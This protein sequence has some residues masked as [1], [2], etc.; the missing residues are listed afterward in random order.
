MHNLDLSISESDVE[1]GATRLLQYVRPE[2]NKA[3][4]AFKTFTDGI[5]NK[6]V[7]CYCESGP[8]DDLVLIRI[9]GKNTELLIDRRAE[10]ATMKRLALIGCAAPLYATFRNGICY[11]YVPGV[12]LDED[13]VRDETVRRLVAEMFVKFHRLQPDDGE[14]PQP[15][16]FPVLKQYHRLIPKSFADPERDRRL[17]CHIPPKAALGHELLVLEQHL[18]TLRSPVVFC[19]NDVL[20]KN[21]IY[22]GDCGR[23]TFIDYEY[24][25]FNYQAFDIG[26]HF[27]EFSGLVGTDFSR[28]PDRSFQLAWL[29]TYLEFWNQ[30]RSGAPREVSSC[31]VETLYVQVNKFALASHFMWG[32]WGLVQAENSTIDFDFLGFAIARFGEYF[33][34]KEEFMALRLPDQVL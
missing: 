22:D 18:S 23:I 26:N 34:R 30:G 14:R 28:Y 15:L 27:C 31:D 6:L 24:A 3:D 21:V 10:V 11:G 7:G 20:L 17:R 29:R 13:S 8:A 16:L 33:S 2:W 9:Y 25:G 32:L 5:T 1:S 19:H 12:T 4:I